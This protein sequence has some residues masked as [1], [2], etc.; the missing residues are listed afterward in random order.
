M[1]LGDFGNARVISLASVTGASLT[2]GTPEYVAPEVFMRRDAEPRSDLYSL[3]VV[4]YE[5][6]LTGRLPWSR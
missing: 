6:V 5:R 1:K 3:G 2:W 4:M